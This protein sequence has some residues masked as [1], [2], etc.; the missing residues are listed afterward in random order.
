MKHFIGLFLSLLL[1][2]HFL[3]AQA[4]DT[5]RISLPEMEVEERENFCVDVTV[6]N[7]KDLA[8]LQFA[9]SWD[10]SVLQIRDVFIPSNMV[11]FFS[12]GNFGIDRSSMNAI[13]FSWI[14][15]F[16]NSITLPDN[17]VIFQL[18]FRALKPVESTAVVFDESIMPL[19]A[20][21]LDLTPVA[22]QA[23]GTEIAVKS[24]VPTVQ[25]ASIALGSI[26]IP[27]GEEACTELSVDGFSDV[28]SVF[29]AL[30]WDADLF[31]ATNVDNE[32]YLELALAPNEIADLNLA[33]SDQLMRYCFKA[34]GDIG[35]ISPISI[36]SAYARST[37]ADIVEIELINGTMEI[38]APLL[39][40]STIAFSIPSVAVAAGRSFC[41]DVMATN[42][43]DIVNLQQSLEWDRS[44]LHLKNVRINEAFN[45]QEFFTFSR[46]FRTNEEVIVAWR[47]NKE[48][49]V[50]I[51][52]GLPL[53][54]LC[55]EAA[56]VLEDTEVTIAFKQG[57][58]NPERVL[59][60]IGGILYELPF[61][62]QSGSVLISTQVPDGLASVG[63]ASSIKAYPNPASDFL[64]LQLGQEKL[65]KATVLDV[66]GK[67]LI[68]T[69]TS[70]LDLRA[71]ATGTYWLVA[72]TTTNT[73]RLP[74]QIQR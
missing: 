1:S 33:I 56:E 37:S 23:L 10:E 53:Y 39:L 35:S 54:E 31:E 55:F 40:P 58:P 26:R 18:C 49:A 4:T 57:K 42:F 6:E 29:L 70:E 16:L 43:D 44:L 71:L 73:H 25:Q 59:Q 34:V 15:E 65:V 61:T 12:S 8:S 9:I 19:E 17:T 36:E 3:I 63:V 11:A 50:T 2:S 30:S 66:A 24:R 27:F 72:Q 13:R 22:I 21:Q 52:A 74:I 64:Q 46:A 60:N 45:A 67:V 28:D 62:Y 48:N 5:L 68:E 41:V 20:F 7:F 69:T 51:P 14:D 47:T 32:G 38:I